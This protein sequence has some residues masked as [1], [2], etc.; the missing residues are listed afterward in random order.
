MVTIPPR[1]AR[2]RA[3]ACLALLVFLPACTGQGLGSGGDVARTPW[4]PM[5][6]L[7]GQEQEVA[8]GAPGCNELGEV[9]VTESENDVSIET[10]RISLPEEDCQAMLGTEVITVALDAPL[11]D[12]ELHG[13]DPFESGADDCRRHDPHRLSTSS[14]DPGKFGEVDDP[15]FPPDDG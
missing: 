6:A 13:C 12:R 14:E 10:S 5:T 4:N 9:E 11:G 8:I 15:D 3:A 1:P 2:G 7:N